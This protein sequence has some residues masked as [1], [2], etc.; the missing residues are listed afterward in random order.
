MHVQHLRQ[1]E[2][3][4]SPVGS[5]AFCQ[6]F[7]KKKG[8]AA[9]KTAEAIA[10]LPDT[11]VALY[12]MR[13][14]AD[15]CR[16]GYLAR[17]TPSSVCSQGL[18]IFDQKL[19]GSFEK[20]IGAATS[21]DQWVQ[22]S[23]PTKKGGFGLR[24]AVASAD[25]AY[26]AS[27]WATFATCGEVR[28]GQ[29]WEG[30][31]G[32][33]A[34]AGAIARINERLPVCAKVERGAPTAERRGAQKELTWKLE[35]EEREGLKGRMAA[36]DKAR[37]DV[38]SATNA[39]R[40]QEAIP[41]KTLDM[42]FTNVEATVLVALQLGVDVYGE[43]AFCPMCGMVS[44]RKGIH[45]SSCG[46]GG[47][48]VLR[49]NAVRDVT[50]GYCKRGRLRPELEKEG[51]L[52]DLGTPSGRRPAD[53]LVCASL[54]PGGLAEQA[55]GQGSSRHALVFAVVNPLGLGNMA[56]GGVVEALAAASAYAER[57]R[58]HNR[59][60]ER[61][62]EEGIEFVP[63]VLAAQGGLEKTTAATFHRITAA[64]AGAE[65]REHSEVKAEM[66]RRISFEL[67]RWA[68]RAVI[69][70]TPGARPEQGRRAMASQFLRQARVLAE[71]E[72]QE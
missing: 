43:E 38:F 5:V 37:L 7:G 46:C 62:K 50:Y 2:I 19:R 54:G 55:G 14:C 33:S 64:V 42:H 60:A 59:T 30:E 36:G 20:T 66:L 48:G 71:A 61:C 56:G 10:D 24:R 35:H 11:H 52:H 72:R 17:T 32:D 58:G 40:W 28:P 68:A 25:A 6:K 41:S 49:H 47:E 45:A 13:E 15:F 31:E 63:M 65:G 26:V 39:G 3:V 70:R 44:D 4:K 12:L 9:A 1:F 67:A 27:R 18:R 23:L 34:L 21:E 22:A 8:E 16:M 53:V 69:R 29:R 51:L 57:K